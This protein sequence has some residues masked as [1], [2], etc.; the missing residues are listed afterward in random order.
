MV[1]QLQPWHENI[2]KP[3]VKAPRLY[4]VD[5]ALFHSL[6]GIADLDSLRRHPK[7]SPSREGFALEEIIQRHG[8]EPEDTDF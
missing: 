8:A 5:S 2:E 7:A 3:Q 4:L 6:M 1:G